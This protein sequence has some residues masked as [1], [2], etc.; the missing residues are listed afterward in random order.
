[1]DPHL[2]QSWRAVPVPWQRRWGRRL[3]Y[4]ILLAGI[5]VVAGLAYEPTAEAFQLRNSPPP[6]RVIP[7]NGMDMH[8]QVGGPVSKPVV[9]LFNEWGMPS[10]SWSWVF[11][12]LTQTNMVVRW[13][14]PGYAWSAIG[15]GGEDASAQADRIYAALKAFDVAGPYILVGSG[16]G[17]VEARIFAARH[18]DEVGGMVLMDPWHP[19][20]MGEASAR[21]EALDHEATLR[22]FSWHR[23]R[24]WWVK[25]KDPDFGLPPQDATVVATSM[26]TMKLARAQAAELRSLPQSFQAAQ[27]NQTLEQKPFWVL[28]SSSLDSDGS[29]G[30]WSPNTQ[31]SRLQLDNQLSKLSTQGKHVI[32]PNAT[33]T[34]LIC[35]QDLADQVVDA[36]R[37]CTGR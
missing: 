2:D 11:G 3:F 23:F 29:A 1:M 10:A 25:A 33:P 15:A 21:A 18:M 17:A 20:L 27:E 7:A 13:D 9:V 28:T 16:L 4:L 5:V 6:G 19:S 30:P 22:R 26:K 12:K 34:T 24:A 31:A 37:A 8:M 32:V 14:P 35:H 36:V